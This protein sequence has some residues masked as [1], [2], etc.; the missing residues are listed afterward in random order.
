MYNLIMNFQT[1]RILLDWR[2]YNNSEYKFI[3]IPIF[4]ISMKT[5]GHMLWHVMYNHHLKNF[6]VMKHL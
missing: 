5:Y 3:M 4:K 6:M 1:L 2:G